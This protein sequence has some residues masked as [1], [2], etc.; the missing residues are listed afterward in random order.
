[1]FTENKT[2][3]NAALH[4]YLQQIFKKLLDG[5]AA[6]DL[7]QSLENA[8]TWVEFRGGECL[9][10]QNDPADAI[11]ILVAGRL[12]VC[13]QN[14]ADANAERIVGEVKHGEVVGKMAMFAKE[15]RSASIY[16]LRDSI[17]A[18]LTHKDFQIL[19]AQYP[20]IFYHITR[21][22]L[23][24][25]NKTVSL[26]KTPELTHEVSSIAIV[27][28]NAQTDTSTF[29]KNLSKA[30][31]HIGKTLHL[32][33]KNIA[34]NL[35]LPADEIT[36]DT[37]FKITPYLAEKEQKNRFVLY[38]ADPEP[39]P[40]TQRCLRQADLVLIVGNE[41]TNPY[42]SAMLRQLLYAPQPATKAKTNLVLL[43]ATDA[44]PQ[45][46]A[47]WLQNHPNT[48]HHHHVCPHLPAHLARLAR[49]LGGKCIGL[50]LGGGGARGLAHI[51]I[52]KALRQHNVP[53]DAVGGTSMGALIGT[54]A[55]LGW[56]T[57]TIETLCK[58]NLSNWKLLKDYTLPTVSMVTGR[59]ADTALQNIF[60]DI[61]I[62]NT[63][64][65]YFCVSS[66][67]TNCE[68]EIHQHGSLAQALRASVSLPVIFPPVIQNQKML[69]DG[70]LMNNLPADIM[71]QKMKG[72]TIIAD[73]MPQDNLDIIGKKKPSLV[74]FILE[75]TLS[76]PQKNRTPD[77]LE[78]IMRASLLNSSQKTKHLR[79]YATLFLQPPVK[80]FGLLE[81]ASI[82]KIADIGYQYTHEML[83]NLPVPINELLEI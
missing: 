30:M 31:A 55:A 61:Q 26:A 53:I 57:D 83:N 22:T 68:I 59:T 43:H 39:T 60:G 48:T 74:S 76:I 29:A 44:L 28:A 37:S 42:P 50:V 21:T 73:V 14:P 38:E 46:T 51:G 1:M 11:Y 75:K 4:S 80:N 5:D 52:I 16:A 23:N 56:D 35:D 18:R 12:Q 67:L 66:N 70:G 24:R 54:A 7:L 32:N 15:R 40:W 33:S 41:N 45:N 78:I 77:I 2:I 19:A 62:E 17:V 65:N 3:H 82:S 69:I 8:V 79:Q 64:L 27:A 20:Q 36:A 72:K 6:D 9:F 34:K 10:K 63:W 58:K 47:I 81:M 49:I 25:L 13:V 71:Y